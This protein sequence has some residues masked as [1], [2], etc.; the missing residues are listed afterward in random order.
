MSLN[1]AKLGA[2][3]KVHSYELLE[4]IG[5]GGM[6]EVYLCIKQGLPGIRNFYAVKVTKQTNAQDDRLSRMFLDEA[7]VMASIRHP[8]LVALHDVLIHEGQY[9]IVMEYLKGVDARRLLRPSSQERR[10]PLPAAI[11]V[12]MIH[13]ACAGLHHSHTAKSIDG[14]ELRL[15]H[16]DI[17][18]HNLFVTFDGFVKILDFG[19]AKSTLQHEETEQGVL[20]GKISYLSP[21][22]CAMNG[23]IDKRADVYALGVVLYEFLT[24]ARP[25]EGR[26]EIQILQLILQGAASPP[27]S[28][29]PQLPQALSEV[30]MR[31]IAVRPEDR[32]QDCEALAEALAKVAKQQGWSLSERRLAAYMDETQQEHKASLE[33]KLLMWL[34]SST[35]EHDGQDDIK[36]SFE[37]TGKR[38]V[39][40]GQDCMG[41]L[42]K[43]GGVVG[44]AISGQIRETFEMG[45]LLEH[46]KGE[47]L[48]L[49]L[50]EVHRVT[51]FGIRQW[52]VM[53][54]ELQ[55]RFEVIYL[56]R[57]SGAM[58]N[59]IVT[60]PAMTQDLKLLSLMAP[61]RCSSC[62]HLVEVPIRAQEDIPRVIRC[63]RC[64]AQA[65]SFDEDELY[66]S[67]LSLGVRPE[68]SIAKL[69]DELE[70]VTPRDAELAAVEKNVTPSHTEIKLS[71]DV[72]LH[73]RWDRLLAGVEGELRVHFAPGAQLP[74]ESWR[75]LDAMLRRL[76]GDVTTTLWGFPL[77]SM[78]QLSSSLLGDE[79]I[80][81]VLWSS[82]CSACSQVEHR[83][84]KLVD[85]EAAAICRRCGELMTASCSPLELAA[86]TSRP[87]APLKVPQ[88]SRSSTQLKANLL[89]LVVIL[90]LI[91]MIL[92]LALC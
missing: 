7:R 8:N 50:A 16:R 13:Q 18:P 1:G 32:Y 33:A 83:E 22:Q 81:S 20:K 37:D 70:R 63:E 14:A 54:P 75:R 88:A 62:A 19:I 36:V 39:S 61:F 2:R 9:L 78:E 51:S 30:V 12:N 31:A 44:C 40:L 29:V 45:P 84:W 58:T 35:H 53:L 77:D 11:A 69:L 10:A 17:S 6:A 71:G 25:F 48:V 46:A 34:T 41:T 15:V 65:S 73:T 56:S 89:Y 80:K 87:V 47:R 90:T 82:A 26:S 24:G 76:E 4:R 72:S 23:M 57:V 66:L 3:S 42:H 85:Q 91:A 43:V 21:E 92:I 68:E 52:L 55:R 38:R 86:Q 60:I 59:Q 5:E 79:R 27:T 28:Y 67:P 64:G 74:Q 49:D